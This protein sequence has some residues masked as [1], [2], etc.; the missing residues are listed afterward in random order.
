MERTQRR[1]RSTRRAPRLCFISVR[2][3]SSLSTCMDRSRRCYEGLTTEVH[4]VHPSQLLSV[5]FETHWPWPGC[6]L[7]AQV[8]CVGSPTPRGEAVFLRRVREQHTVS[9]PRGVAQAGR[10]AGPSHTV[11][12][13]ALSYSSLKASTRL[14]FFF[15]SSCNQ[16]M[17]NHNPDDSCLVKCSGAPLPAK[18]VRRRN[19]LCLRMKSVPGAWATASLREL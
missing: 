4:S 2:M 1:S 16:P 11:G 13:R 5:S 12:A 18:C 14:F 19:A 3:R 17:I 6:V 9:T 7:G 8:S 10:G 15:E